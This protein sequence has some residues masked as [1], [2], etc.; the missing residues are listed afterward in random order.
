MGGLAFANETPLLPTPRMRPSV[1]TH[2]RDHLLNLLGTFYAQANSPIEAPGKAD[3]GDID[4]LVAEPLHDNCD[5][6][7]IAAVIGAVKH[8]KTAGSQTTHFAVPWPELPNPDCDVHAANGLAKSNQKEGDQRYIQLDL[9]VCMPESFSWEVFHHSHGDFWNIIGST[10][11]S[12]GLTPSNSGFYVRIEEIEAKNR[13]A[14]RLQL[15]T[16]PSETLKF[17]GLD[18]SRYWQ[19]FDTVDELFAYA[20]T[21]RFFNPKKYDPARAKGD[22]KAN[23][24]ARARKRAVFRSWVEEYLPGHVE[25]CPADALAAT[26]DRGKV[27]EEAKRWFGVVDEYE[28][29]RRN[30]IREIR[31]DRMWTQIRKE[32]DIEPDSVGAVIRGVKREVVGAEGQLETTIQRAYAEDDFDV[33]VQWARENWKEIEQR[34]RAL[35]KEKST[36]NLLAKLERLRAEGKADADTKLGRAKKEIAEDQDGLKNP[37]EVP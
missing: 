10:I 37:E 35:E 1:Y 32:L 11:R 6:A 14:A 24:R 13:N 31:R 21:C 27:V 30:G 4:I 26:M 12:L 18:E 20:A 7:Q 2:V 15:T 29:K 23:D 28:N 22:L 19:K 3:Y 8:K 34:Q 33:V 36:Q 16:S 5:A 17:L 25:D 9:H